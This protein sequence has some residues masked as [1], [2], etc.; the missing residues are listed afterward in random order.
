MAVALFCKDLQIGKEAGAHL[1]AEGPNQL[2]NDEAFVSK[3]ILIKESFENVLPAESCH[4][5]Q[6]CSLDKGPS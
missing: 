5:G 3:K 4:L 2:H 6:P 1:V